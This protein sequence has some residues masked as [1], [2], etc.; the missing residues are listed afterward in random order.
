[1][2][3]ASPITLSK[4]DPSASRTRDDHLQREERKQCK[5]MRVDMIG[6]LKVDQQ[7]CEQEF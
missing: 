4:Q 2:L 3:H 5:V 6:G 1:M 7:F